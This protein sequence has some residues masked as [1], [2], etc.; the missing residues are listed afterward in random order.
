MDQLY[1]FFGSIAPNFWESPYARYPNKSRPELD[2]WCQP[3]RYELNRQ[4]LDFQERLN[5]F[6][7]YA[8]TGRRQEIERREKFLIFYEFIN[9]RKI[10]RVCYWFRQLQILVNNLFY[11]ILLVFPLILRFTLS[12]SRFDFKL[13][14]V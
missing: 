1:I 9:V 12:F 13:I 8:L 14:T 7:R 6:S 5:A 2:H 3:L 10:D 4:P 11:M